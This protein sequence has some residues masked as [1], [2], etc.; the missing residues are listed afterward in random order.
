MPVNLVAA[1]ISCLVMPLHERP[2]RVYDMGFRK[3]ARRLLT[4]DLVPA[5]ISARVN[6]IRGFKLWVDDS[7]F[8]KEPFC[9]NFP[10]LGIRWTTAW[11][12]TV[13]ITGWTN[14]TP[15]PPGARRCWKQRRRMRW[16]HRPTRGWRV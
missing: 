8:D 13:S 11:N 6:A 5:K 9:H 10:A 7:W 2:Y 3:N 4:I 1:F 15:T 12:P 14:M 16:R